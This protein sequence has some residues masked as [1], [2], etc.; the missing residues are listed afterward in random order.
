MIYPVELEVLDEGLTFKLRERERKPLRVEARPLGKPFDM[1]F[2]DR[3]HGNGDSYGGSPRYG[4]FGEQLDIEI[5]KRGLS[6]KVANAY[7]EVSPDREVSAKR[8]I[9]GNH[10]PIERPRIVTRRIQLYSIK[11]EVAQDQRAFTAAFVAAWTT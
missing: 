3:P 11:K 9:Y 4:N 5:E 2:E 1:T 6:P 10:P 7:L 8:T